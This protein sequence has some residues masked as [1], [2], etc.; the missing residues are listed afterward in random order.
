MIKLAC[1][2]CLLPPNEMAPW[3]VSHITLNKTLALL[4]SQQD[5]YF[6]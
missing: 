3:A 2:N 1:L 4:A 5:E 6:A